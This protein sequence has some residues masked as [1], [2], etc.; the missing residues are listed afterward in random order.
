[1]SHA[2]LCNDVGDL[3]EEIHQTFN[4]YVGQIIRIY[5]DHDYVE[6]DWVIGPI[7]IE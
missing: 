2:I 4:N 5:K 6:F 7:P 3:V 1:M